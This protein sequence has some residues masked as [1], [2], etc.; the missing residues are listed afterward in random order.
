MEPP[1]I[2]DHRP[3][4]TQAM[5]P[6]IDDDINA[7]VFRS[8]APDLLRSNSP[9]GQAS[10]PQVFG[11]PAIGRPPLAP[12]QPS[13][14]SRPPSRPRGSANGFQNGHNGYADPNGEQSGRKYSIDGD[15]VAESIAT[16]DLGHHSIGQSQPPPRSEKRSSVSSNNN[17]DQRS[18]S[19]LSLDQQSLGHHS[20]GGPSGGYYS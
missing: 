11:Q 12:R 19:D 9:A 1:S 8:S 14:Q 2:P 15:S 7:P 6:T 18:V 16:Q 3:H 10:R 4:R 5:A 13:A 17:F 20:I